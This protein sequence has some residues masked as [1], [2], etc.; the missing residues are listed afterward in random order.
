[1]LLEKDLENSFTNGW[2]ECA[3]QKVYFPN[4]FKLKMVTQ[5]QRSTMGWKQTTLTFN[6]AKCEPVICWP[7][8]TL[9]LWDFS[10]LQ[11]SFLALN[12]VCLSMIFLMTHYKGRILMVVGGSTVFTMFLCPLV[13]QVR[14]WVANTDLEGPWLSITWSSCLSDQFYFLQ[15][16]SLQS[17]EISHFC[18]L[19][20]S[21]IQAEEW[22]NFIWCSFHLM[23]PC[24]WFLSS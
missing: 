2:K 1:M 3:R 16:H 10:P 21:I 5:R 24:P 18:L 6:S 19:S 4:T 11:K 7:V 17:R 14:R 13:K 22:P 9:I 20:P 23:F 8:C 15:Q 12:I